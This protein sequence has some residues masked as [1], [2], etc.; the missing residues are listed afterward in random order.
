MHFDVGRHV[1]FGESCFEYR[2]VS[3]K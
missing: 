3:R 2:R 1:L